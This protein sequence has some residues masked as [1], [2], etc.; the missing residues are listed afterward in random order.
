MIQ[1]MLFL[2]SVIALF[3]FWG[4]FGYL[5]AHSHVDVV[6]LHLFLLLFAYASNNKGLKYICFSFSFSKNRDPP[7]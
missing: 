4:Q 5:P 2:P 3:A 7:L 1:A 6:M